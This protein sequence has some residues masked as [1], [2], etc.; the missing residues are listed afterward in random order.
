MH[1]VYVHWTV[2]PPRPST[3]GHIVQPHNCHIIEHIFVPTRSVEANIEKI[4]F[5]WVSSSKFMIFPQIYPRSNSKIFPNV[6]LLFPVSNGDSPVAT[7]FPR[8][9]YRGFFTTGESYCPMCTLCNPNSHCRQHQRNS[10]P[11]TVWGLGEWPATQDWRQDQDSSLY[12]LGASRS[13]EDRR[14]AV[15]CGSL[16]ISESS[17]VRTWIHKRAIRSLYVPTNLLQ[18]MIPKIS[19]SSSIWSVCRRRRFC[20]RRQHRRRWWAKHEA[21]PVAART[22]VKVATRTSYQMMGRA[23]HQLDHTCR[24]DSVCLAAAHRFSE[25]TLTENLQLFDFRSCSLDCVGSCGQDGKFLGWISGEGKK[26]RWKVD[27]RSWEGWLCEPETAQPDTERVA[28]CFSKF[29]TISL[30]EVT[31]R[32]A[33][34]NSESWDVRC[35]RR[36]DKIDDINKVGEVIGEE[37]V[38]RWKADALRD[39]A[40]VGRSEEQQAEG[41][42]GRG[43]RHL[44][45]CQ[46]EFSYSAS[47]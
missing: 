27:L 28:N 17:S 19:W 11:N 32:R 31:Q 12:L 1:N 25:E 24:A 33:E 16:M 47:L 34:N 45:D 38:L 42:A 26:W 8:S 41:E 37:W 43:G 21:A 46:G 4:W 44:E 20:R 29:S 35:S 40:S 36:F 30:A 18:A 13:Q 3:V 14:L 7:T 23:A 9:N 6:P 22:F 39:A 10:H 15:C 5:P 2:F